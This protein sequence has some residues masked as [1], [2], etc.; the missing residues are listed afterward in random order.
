M[1]FKVRHIIDYFEAGDYDLLRQIDYRNSTHGGK[2][3]YGLAV[4]IQHHPLLLNGLQESPI[5][6][7]TDLGCGDA[8][9]PL[10]AQATM[11]RT[12]HHLYLIERDPD[13]VNASF[14]NLEML[15]P[16]Q[17]RT[18]DLLP[19]SFTDDWDFYPAD[20]IP[21]V[22][23]YLNNFGNCLREAEHMLSEKINNHSAVGSVVICYD[24]MFCHYSNW[25]L[26]RVDIVNLPRGQCS[27]FCHHSEPEYIY[28]KPLS[29]FKYTKIHEDPTQSRSLRSSNVLV[30]TVSYADFW[31]QHSIV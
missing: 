24:A 31:D 9:F 8:F 20:T 1:K 16:R 23:Y 7:I 4:L 2:T 3:N 10:L 18:V 29:V 27:W 14:S 17:R 30:S 19:M 13:R 21:I 6:I 12:L 11:H 15:S 26:E 22:A 28:S 25:N 5:N